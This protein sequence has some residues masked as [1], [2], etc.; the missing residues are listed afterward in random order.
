MGVAAA[1]AS[2]GL[3]LRRSKSGSLELVEKKF[4][5]T[6]AALQQKVRFVREVSTDHFLHIVRVG[7]GVIER[8]LIESDPAGLPSHRHNGRPIFYR[9]SRSYS[10]ININIQKIQFGFSLFHLCVWIADYEVGSPLA[11]A[12][13][14]YMTGY[15]VRP[16]RA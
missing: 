10:I 5:K 3:R 13:M 12:C 6:R 9:P 7:E 16:A 1:A 15:S 4:A 11:A 8:W 2:D 14:L